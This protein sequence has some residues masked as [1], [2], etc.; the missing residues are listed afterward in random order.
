MSVQ[1]PQ[2]NKL[3]GSALALGPK[4]TRAHPVALPLDLERTVVVRSTPLGSVTRTATR[5]RAY[6]GAPV[7]L[8]LGPERSTP[9]RSPASGSLGTLAVYRDGTCGPAL[10]PYRHSQFREGGTQGR[11]ACR[12]DAATKAGATLAAPNEFKR[13]APAL[14]GD[15][16]S[17]SAAATVQPRVKIESGERG[18][19]RSLTR[20][21]QLREPLW[22][23][24]ARR[25]PELQSRLLV[26][27]H[28]QLEGLRRSDAMANAKVKEGERIEQLIELVLTD[29]LDL[30]KCVSRYPQRVVVRTGID[31]SHLADALVVHLKDAAVTAG[32]R[33]MHQGVPLHHFALPLRHGSTQDLGP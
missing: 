7:A 24:D 20:F 1:C 33:N 31:E 15:V 30:D 9:V 32:C 8:P 3:P 21:V 2:V 5:P 27:A 17:R 19:Q 6:P 4:R 28:K 14:E 10:P 18:Q 16:L 25:E 29:G 13:P 12:S 26:F 23:S 22:R 11:K